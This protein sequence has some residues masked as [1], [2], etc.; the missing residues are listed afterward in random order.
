MDPSLRVCGGEEG[1]GGRR[2][3]G[4][5]RRGREEERGRMEGEGSKV[6]LMARARA[7]A[8]LWKVQD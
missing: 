5:K 2:E 4:K 1:G 3:G 6:Q 7:R 8:E